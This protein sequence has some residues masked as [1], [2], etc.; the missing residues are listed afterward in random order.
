MLIGKANTACFSIISRSGVR[1]LLRHGD[2]LK[3]LHPTDFAASLQAVI[4]S[5]KQAVS[6]DSLPFDLKKL[7]DGAL[8]ID[9]G[10]SARN[11]RS[12]RRI[13]CG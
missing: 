6:G 3:E 11:Q 7:V 4:D 12:P 8:S 10:K 2:P 9:G 1:G 13:S 5:L